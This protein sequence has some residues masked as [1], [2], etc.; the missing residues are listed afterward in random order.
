MK[1]FNTIPSMI[2]IALLSAGSALAQR[3]TSFTENAALRYWS[4]F[5]EVQDSG[6]TDQQAKELNAIVDG[7]APYDDSKYKDLLEKNTLALEI[8]ARATS[9]PNCDW[10]LDY[11]LGHDIPVDYAKKALVLGRLNVLYAFHLLK[12]GNKDGAVRALAAGLRFSHDVGNGGS[13]FAT[14]IAKDL[15]TGHLRAVA[16][17]LRLEQLSAGQRSQLQT[18]VARVGEGL[19]WPMAAKRDLEALRGDYAGNSQTSAALTR[20]I[21]SYVAALNDESKLPALDQ[22][23]QGAPQELANVIPNAKRVLEQKQDLNN[24]LL[25]TR[26]LLQ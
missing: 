11:G 7:T 5:S 1:I 23:V 26:A 6:I 24:T 19:D 12:T 4:A 17:A 15:L 22:A 25:Q 14:L 16:G 21:S 8:M 18:A 9:L 13:L 10:G 2:L 20:I 3:N